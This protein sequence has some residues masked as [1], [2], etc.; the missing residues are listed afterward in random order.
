MKGGVAMARKTVIVSD[1]SGAEI[2]EGKGANVVI[3]YDDARKPNRQ[4]DVTADEAD[5]MG[6]RVVARR[7]RRPKAAEAAS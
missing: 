2:E 3:K 5:K 4:L 6:G 7:G 1:M